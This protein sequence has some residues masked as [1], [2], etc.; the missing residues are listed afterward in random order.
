MIAIGI[1]DELK[2]NTILSKYL[3]HICMAEGLTAVSA[4][5]VFLLVAFMCCEII[6]NQT[7][8][9]DRVVCSDFI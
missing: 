8:S 5:V 3:N 9:I 1:L 4:L 7:N 6:E 2:N